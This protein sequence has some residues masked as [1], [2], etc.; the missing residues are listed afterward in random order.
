MGERLEKGVKREKREERERENEKRKKN[1]SYNV[2]LNPVESVLCSLTKY[3]HTLDYQSEFLVIVTNTWTS[4][5]RTIQ[6][7]KVQMH[8]RMFLPRFI[9]YCIKVRIPRISVQVLI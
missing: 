8:H 9:H 3:A 7:R 1:E 4:G 6:T 2:Q 5:S